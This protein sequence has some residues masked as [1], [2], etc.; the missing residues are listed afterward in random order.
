MK[1]MEPL[2]PMTPM[3]PLRPMEPT[4]RW[5]PENLGDEPSTAGGQ[6]EMR[7]A[8]FADKNRL[9]VDE[10]AGKISVYDTEGHHVSGVQ[11]DQGGS[12]RKLVF[13]SERGEIDLASLKRV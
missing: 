5:W 2:K 8:Y 6:N 12:S 7:Y 11:Q 9:A 1:P 4:Q 13:T 3:K 10:G